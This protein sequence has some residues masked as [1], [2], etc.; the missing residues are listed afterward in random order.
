[1]LWNFSFYNQIKVCR[2]S[3]K[4]PALYEL[5]AKRRRQ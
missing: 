2:N 3:D 5:K 1:V 4:L